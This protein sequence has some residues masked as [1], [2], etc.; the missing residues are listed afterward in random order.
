MKVAKRFS[1]LLCALLCSCSLLQVAEAACD[2]YVGTNSA[3]KRTHILRI[4]DSSYG[5]IVDVESFENP[6]NPY[7]THVMA[8][9]MMQW[10]NIL[11]KYA[12]KLIGMGA[13]EMVFT[14]THYQVN[15]DVDRKGLTITTNKAHP[16]ERGKAFMVP[17]LENHY[18]YRMTSKHSASRNAAR[19]LLEYHI[20]DQINSDTA[21]LIRELNHVNAHYPKIKID[22]SGYVFTFAENGYQ[23]PVYFIDS[24]LETIWIQWP[25]GRAYQIYTVGVSG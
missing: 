17:G 13:E 20:D 19:V 18:Q 6:D 8:S 10:D 3:G 24:Q 23:K 1:G 21:L 12:D 5:D 22:S 7:A 2:M 15:W 14:N 25:D 9:G 4:Y 11:V 16:G